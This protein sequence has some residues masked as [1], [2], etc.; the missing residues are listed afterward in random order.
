LSK[1]KIG[2]GEVVFCGFAA[3]GHSMG[4]ETEALI[5]EDSQ[6]KTPLLGLRFLKRTIMHNQDGRLT[7]SQ[8]YLR[9]CGPTVFTS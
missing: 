3:Y 1:A 2:P 9:P 8:R 7:L 6:L 4:Q 5:M